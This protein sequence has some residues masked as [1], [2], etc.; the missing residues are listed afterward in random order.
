MYQIFLRVT[1]FFWCV[2]RSV[3][4]GGP[5]HDFRLL[6]SMCFCGILVQNQP[7]QKT[8]GITAHK[9]GPNNGTTRKIDFAHFCP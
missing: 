3:L 2:S 9:Y 5:A 4:G 7:P 8:N 6:R 1:C